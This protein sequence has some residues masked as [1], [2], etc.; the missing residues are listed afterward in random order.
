MIGQW[1]FHKMLGFSNSLK[2]EQQYH[3]VCTNS[4]SML[5]I[6]KKHDNIFIWKKQTLTE[7]RQPAFWM[8][9]NNCWLVVGQKNIATVLGY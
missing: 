8:S 3:A 4:N 2:Q 5:M 1:A 6:H 7:P 9:Q